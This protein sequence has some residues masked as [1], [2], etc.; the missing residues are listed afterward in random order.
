MYLASSYLAQL[1]AL[2]PT[3]P[4]W[5]REPDAVLTRLLTA[6]AEEFARIDERIEQLED[7]TDPR[8]AYELLADWERVLGL[9]DP[10]TAAATTI[11]ARQA[12]CWRKLAYQAGQTPAFY[13]ALAASIGFEIEIH[14][15]DPDIDDWD[16]SLTGLIGGGRYRYV[17]RVHVLN[18]GSL[19]YFRAGDPVGMRLREGDVGIDVECILQAAKPAHT[20]IVFSYPEAGIPEP[21]GPPT[22]ED[23][24]DIDVPTDTPTDIDL[25]SH[26][27]GG[28]HTSIAASDGA[29]GTTH[30]AGDVVTYTP[31]AG[32]S[33]ADS[34]TYTATGP[35][36]TSSPATVTVDVEVPAAPSVE[37]VAVTVPMNTAT[38]I[39]LSSHVSG[40][41]TSIATS[42]PSHG[43]RTVSGDVVTYTPT[44]GY[45][46]A[47]SFTWT[48]TGPG[49]TS[50]AETVSIT[51]S[52][53]LSAEDVFDY[54][55]LWN[56]PTGIDLSG[57]IGGTHTSVTVGAAS[58]GT[59]AVA[60]DV[61]TYTPAGG[62]SGT[63]SFTYT[64]HASGGGSATAT[65]HV[66][67][68]A[69]DE[70]E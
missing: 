40:V 69:K 4:A 6:E 18:A 46:G 2:L 63:D 27:G 43:A 36:G 47:D 39:D 70:T 32:Y 15:F 62:F 25:A 67:V 8:T 64:A 49:G 19:D 42:A 14:E 68:G 44:T 21:A 37:D 20:Y 13:V 7:E 59:M 17:W 11:A 35:G 9:P 66:R 10:C 16:G 58:H 23:V 55:I 57:A 26:I 5:P 34:F 1:Q 12:A 24:D 50:A 30:E 3:G 61:V 52:A 28:G 33:G 31:D 22:V 65:V 54:F 53:P 45:S 41:H 38:P 29:H 60:G 56:T 51:V 48:A